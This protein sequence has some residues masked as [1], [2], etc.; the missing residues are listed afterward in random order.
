[1][2]KKKYF[3]FPSFIKNLKIKNNFQLTGV[4]AVGSEDVLGQHVE[5]VTLDLDLQLGNFS[6]FI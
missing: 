2:K 3:E 4:E 5:A 6:I 1:M